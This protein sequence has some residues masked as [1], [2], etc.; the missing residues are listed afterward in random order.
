MNYRTVE[1]HAS[2][3]FTSDTT[4]VIDINI[5]DPIS[6]LVLLTRGLNAS[7]TMTAAICK[8]LSKV[9]LV[10]GSDVIISLDGYELEA[11]DWYHNKGRVR[12]NWNAA[13]NGST[14]D[15]AIGINFGRFLWDRMYAFDPTKFNNPQLRVTIDVDGGGNAVSSFYL[16]VEA[17][18]FDERIPELRGVLMAKELKQW[19]M[20]STV[21]EYTDLPTDYPYRAL[22]LRAFVLGTEPNQC[23]SNIKLSEDTDKKIP[24]DSNASELMR[25]LYDKYPRVVEHYYFAAGTSTKYIY[26]MPSTRVIAQV[27]T[28]AAAAGAA[29]DFAAYDGDGGR[30]QVIGSAGGNVQV[31]IEGDAP[32]CTYEIPFGL[33]DDPDDAYDVTR[34]K[35]L[36]A[37]ITGGATA[38]GYLFLQQY[39]PY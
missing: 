17:N 25:A 28:W 36:R 14:W 30:L 9:E 7:A 18:I 6:S 15:R 24:I 2:E 22:Y 11:L 31:R 26:C 8:C 27:L 21:H 5:N 29:K 1:L 19:T 34:I 16:A 38:V 23:I 12:S 20:A 13:L 10:D 35:S 32:H 37:D 39:R 3:T 33:K 4:K